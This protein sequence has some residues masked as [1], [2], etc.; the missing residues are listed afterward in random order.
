MSLV[1]KKE[2][3]KKKAEFEKEL[4]EVL[5]KLLRRKNG[6][7]EAEDLLFRLCK[8]LGKQKKDFM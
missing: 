1:T 8:E 4:G 7:E 6:A 3:E 5:S 2:I